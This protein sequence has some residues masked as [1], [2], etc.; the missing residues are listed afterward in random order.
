MARNISGS[1]FNMIGR[2]RSPVGV[3]ACLLTLRFTKIL[4][5]CSLN[6]PVDGCAKREEDLNTARIIIIISTY[7]STRVLRKKE[8]LLTWN[9]GLGPKANL[10]EDTQA[11]A[12]SLT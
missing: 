11:V 2:S 7:S 1:Y 6:F 3:V 10:A 5:T 8:S 9:S 4:S 12:M